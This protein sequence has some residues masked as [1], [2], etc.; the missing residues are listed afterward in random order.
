MKE[1]DDKWEDERHQNASEPDEDPMEA[2]KKAEE[3]RGKMVHILQPGENTYAAMKRLVCIFFSQN[4]DTNIY[5]K[6]DKHCSTEKGEQYG[7]F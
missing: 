7:R 3:L 5:H 6:P 2:K 4:V 1:L